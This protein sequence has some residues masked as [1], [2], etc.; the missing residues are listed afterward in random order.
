LQYLVDTKVVAPA[1]ST[2]IGQK[3]GQGSLVTEFRLDVEVKVLLP[4]INV[5]DNMLRMRQRLENAHLT[6]LVFSILMPVVRLSALL[7]SKYLTLDG[8]PTSAVARCNVS[9]RECVRMLKFGHTV[10]HGENA[11]TAQLNFVKSRVQARVDVKAAST[12][13]NWCDKNAS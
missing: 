4:I 10:H 1:M 6:K 9:K 5:S 2:N 13:V 12:G 11:F 7:D 3:F 8:A